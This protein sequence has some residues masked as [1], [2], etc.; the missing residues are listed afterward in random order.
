MTITRIL[1]PDRHPGSPGP[2]SP[3][4][5]AVKDAV[6]AAGLPLRQVTD[7]LGAGFHI[8][9][10][11][12]SGWSNG[13]N[14]PDRTGHTL[15]R[16][17]ALERV[18]RTDPGALVRAYHSISPGPWDLR[19]PARH[20][21]APSTPQAT[22]RSQKDAL[23]AR[24]CTNEG[25]VALVDVA[26]HHRIGDTRLPVRS[27]VRLTALA[28]QPRVRS[29]WVTYTVDEKAPRA[30]LAGPGCTTGEQD[31]VDG[32]GYRV[33]AVELRLD[34]D[35][36]VG[37]T[38]DLAFSVVFRPPAPDPGR[39]PPAGYFRVVSDPSCRRLRMELSFPPCQR[40][41][42]VRW[43][44]WDHDTQD[45]L[46][47]AGTPVRSADG[48]F[49]RVLTDPGLTA[50]GYLWSWPAAHETAPPAWGGVR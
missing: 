1:A 41:A 13:I 14:V 12:L 20:P 29:Y 36:E 24:G 44:A 22:P 39:I 3:F 47:S 16:L 50:Y 2:D 37:D 10:A 18:L 43:V 17:L 8:A 15:G 28:L 35:L 4:A 11:T 26:E 7:R 19:H 40:P 30:I 33:R 38:A 45:R 42:S 23:D 9:P 25:A 27:D 46:S 32:P 21:L 48:H 6:A 31:T 49:D 34:H 5:R